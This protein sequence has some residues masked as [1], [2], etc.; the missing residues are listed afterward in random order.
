[1]KR[2]EMLDKIYYI[3]YKSGVESW[4]LEEKILSEIEEEGMLPPLVKGEHKWEDEDEI[5]S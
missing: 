2:S 4:K 1:M 3:L 5:L